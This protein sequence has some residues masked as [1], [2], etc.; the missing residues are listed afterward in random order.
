VDDY[1]Y[2]GGVGMVLKPGPLFEAVE[3]IEAELRQEGS[4]TPVILLTPQ[5]RLFC[6]RVAQEL[7]TRPNLI[8]ICGHYEGVDERVREYLTSDEISIGDYVLTGGELAAMVVV[9]AVVRLLHGVLNSEQAIKE[10]SHAWGF[11]EYPQYT[12]PRVYRGW[13]VPPALL[14]GNHEEIAKWR[15]EQA[16]K[17]TLKRRP[18]LL[19]RAILSE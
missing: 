4:A 3:S 8:L 14:S 13:G 7:A 10:D 9:D 5:G 17:R 15:R 16:L 2:G 12:R 19:G 11:L 6:Q 18:D 1:P